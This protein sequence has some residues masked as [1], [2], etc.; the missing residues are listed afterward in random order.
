MNRPWPLYS[1]SE[2]AGLP[3]PKWLINRHVTDGMTVM[4]GPPGRGK[5]FLALS[6]ALSIA[7]GTAWQGHSVTSMP[8][9]YVSGEGGGGLA[10]RIGAW[11]VNTTSLAVPKL[12]VILGT[13]VLTNREHVEALR[14]DIRAVGAG[15]LVI[16]TLARSMAGADENSSKDMGLAINGLDFLR[17]DV[18][19]AA[20]VV[21]HSGVEKTRPRGSTALFGAADTI[22]RIDGE[23]ETVDVICEK[24]KEARP[25]RRVALELRETDGSCVLVPATRTGFSAGFMPGGSA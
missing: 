23:D 21:H 8:V 4:Y 12:Y 25:F 3:E 5:T 18:N 19:C 9:L 2:L 17:R 24:Q 10:R 16:D 20:L 11:Q 15:L 14:D 1:I 6:W 7:S 22:I 13:V